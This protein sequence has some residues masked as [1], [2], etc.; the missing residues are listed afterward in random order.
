MSH[1]SDSELER[2]LSDT[3]LVAFMRHVFNSELKRRFKFAGVV[4]AGLSTHAM[5]RGGA[6]ALFM[7]GVPTLS[8]MAH[9]RWASDTWRDYVEIGF[10]QQLLP[11]QLLRDA[12][13]GNAAR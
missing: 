12:R 9:G 10:A 6:T 13:R 3:M 7:A 11:T 2:R 4:K 5:R 8:I 1:E